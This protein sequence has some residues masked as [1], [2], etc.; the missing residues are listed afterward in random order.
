MSKFIKFILFNIIMYTLYILI[1]KIFTFLDLYSNPQ[2]GIDIMV[3]PTNT[4][5]WLILINTL[6]S[7]IGT[8]YIL[9][10]IKDNLDEY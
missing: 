2:L 5:I 4:D 1:D 6:L 3:I 7:S 10:K 9:F 8:F